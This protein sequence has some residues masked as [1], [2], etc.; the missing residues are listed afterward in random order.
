MP[1]LSKL[2]C[3]LC[4]ASRCS[5]FCL[6][7]AFSPRRIFPIF[8]AGETSVPFAAGGRARSRAC[9]RSL[10]FSTSRRS[11]AASFAPTITGAPG[12]RSSTI[13]R[14]ARSA[15]SRSR[16]QIRT[17]S[18]SVAAKALHRP[19]LSVGDGI[20]KSTDAGKTW[21]HLGLRDGQQIAQIAVDPRNPDHLLV[22]V[23]GHPYGPNEER[24]IFLSI[25]G[26]KTFAKTLYKDENTGRQRCADRSDRI[27]RSSTRR[28]GKRVK[29]RG[30]TRNGTGPTAA[31]SNRP[32]AARP[33]SR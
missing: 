16:F 31:S 17:S 12:S 21:T 19:D 1:A 29:V 2:A 25:D 26:G 8:C 32:T 9:R 3:E 13:N 22:A 27:R 15:R 5:L 11:T 23:A 14:P 18:T 4:C 20:Y 28:S 24:G 7:T 30:K 10:T 33:G 6:A